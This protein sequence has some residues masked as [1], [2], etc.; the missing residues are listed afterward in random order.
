[1]ISQLLKIFLGISLLLVVAYIQN[2]TLASDALCHLL[3]RASS[4]II[5]LLTTRIILIPVS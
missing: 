2:T 1:M 5:N 3:L 4:F